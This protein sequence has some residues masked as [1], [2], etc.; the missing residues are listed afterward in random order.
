MKKKSNYQG[1][2]PITPGEESVHVSVRMS[3]RQK[4][5]YLLLGSGKWLREQIDK[6][7]V[8]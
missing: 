5:K 1:R 8:R 2:K 3:F 4:A 7:V 6:A